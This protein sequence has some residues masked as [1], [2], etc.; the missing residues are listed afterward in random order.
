MCQHW[1]F[2]AHSQICLLLPST[3]VKL[4]WREG[5]RRPFT[6]V[7]IRLSFCC[8]APAQNQYKTTPHPPREMLPAPVLIGCNLGV[9]SVAAFYFWTQLLNSRLMSF[10]LFRRRPWPSLPTLIESESAAAIVAVRVARYKY[11]QRDFY[12][13]L[14][15]SFFKDPRNGICT[16]YKSW[17][18]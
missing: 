8:V 9:I 4:H 3:D 1:P 17:T 5:K 2:K 16:Q 10:L 7:S 13:F 12:R 11:E 6:Q 18:K 14:F 15:F